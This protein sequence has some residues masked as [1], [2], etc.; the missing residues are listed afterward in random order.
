[1]N[2]QM[3]LSALTM[4]DLRPV[5]S[6][7]VLEL[8][9][10]A[11]AVAVTAACLAIG[12]LVLA[13]PIG[14]AI[15][16]FGTAVVI[17]AASCAIPVT[18]AWLALAG[19][20]PMICVACLV[21]GVVHLAVS[22]GVQTA[23]SAGHAGLE[24]DTSF[25]N[26]TASASVGQ[27]LGPLAALSLP[28]VIPT[29]LAEHV[30]GL[31]VMAVLSLAGVAM[32]LVQW[33]GRSRTRQQGHAPTPVP[34]VQ[35]LRTAGVTAALLVSGAVLACVDLLSAFLPL[36]ASERNVPAS[37]VAVLLAT[38]GVCTL[39]SRLGMARVVAKLG[40]RRV[41][42]GSVWIGAVGMGALNLSG[43]WAAFGVMVILGI[44]LGFAQP[45]T[46]SWVS[47]RVTEGTRGSALSVRM[48][49][50]RAFQVGVPAC[51][52]WAAP[53]LAGTLGGPAG[54]AFACCAGLLLLAGASAW[55]QPFDADDRDPGPGRPGNQVT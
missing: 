34:V 38:R 13:L 30:L 35:I 21:F 41:L 37:L 12:T 32:A 50:N 19:N 7:R 2:T 53:V 55:G 15:D 42:I 54:A 17:L 31:W 20:V 5:A 29:P 27:T 47:G 14:R 1:M 3:A 49:T 24:M 43:A 18:L 51:I 6:Y 46:M 16:R 45:I 44:G 33:Q 22:V 25:G 28:S 26:L 52:S 4:A 11:P 48:L 40:R 8:G 9:G 36:W 39:V 10:D 23:A